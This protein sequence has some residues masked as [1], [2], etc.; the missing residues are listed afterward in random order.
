MTGWTSVS[1]TGNITKEHMN[2]I[3][4]K[5][6]IIYIKQCTGRDVLKEKYRYVRGSLSKTLNYWSSNP[7]IELG[8]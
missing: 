6:A 8:E 5:T 1:P 2:I 4:R 3:T 7:V